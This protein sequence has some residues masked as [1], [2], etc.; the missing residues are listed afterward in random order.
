MSSA[1]TSLLD[2]SRNVIRGENNRGSNN[3]NEE[4]HKL[5]KLK[6]KLKIDRESYN[7]AKEIGDT[8]WAKVKKK[9]VEKLEDMIEEYFD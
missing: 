1:T 6:K 8:D 2:F 9:I 3:D 5:N 4:N 7:F